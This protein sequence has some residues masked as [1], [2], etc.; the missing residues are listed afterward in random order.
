MRTRDDRFCRGRIADFLSARTWRIA[1]AARWTILSITVWGSASATV[2]PAPGYIDT[3][4]GGGIGDGGAPY[5]AVVD[6][7]GLAFCWGKL[8]IADGQQHR[9]R[10]ADLTAN[11][12]TTLAGTGEAAFGGDGGPAV[13]AKLNT[14]TDV[15]C[16]PDGSLY[17]ADTFNHRVRR[18]APNG[19]I[20]T[21]IGDGRPFSSGDGGPATQ[22]SVNRPQGLALDGNG[23]LYVSE[24]DGYRVRRIAPN[25]IVSTVAGTGQWGSSGDGGP[26]T[27]ARLMNPWGIAVD[28]FGNLFIADYGASRVRRVDTQGIITTVVG[29]G[30]Q[31]FAGDGGPANRARLNRPARL[32]FDLA[33][34][35]YL[36]DILNYRVR[37]VAAVQGLVTGEATIQ[38]IAGT[39]NS[40]DT[41]DFGPATAATFWN[42]WGLAI[43]PAGTIY[44]G[45]FRPS[46]SSTRSVENRVRTIVPSGVVLPLVGGGPGDG[47]IATNAVIEPRGVFAEN[48]G[49]VM[50]VFFAD[51]AHQ[52]VRV[53]DV[54]SGWVTTVAGNGATCSSPTDPCGDGGPAVNAPLGSPMD[55]ARDSSGNL[56]IAEL[57]LHRIRKVDAVTQQISTVAGTGG[58]G[59][60]GDGLPATQSTLAN[61]YAVFVT[62]DASTMYIADFSNL[63]IRRVSS[64]IMTTIAGNGSWGNPPDGAVASQSA[65]GA[66]TDVLLGPD[67]LVYFV[68]NGNHMVRRIARDGTLQRVAGTGWAGFSGDGGPAVSAQLFGP[69][70]ITF[71]ADGNLY[72]ADGNNYRIRRIAAGSGI[73]TTVA[74]T[75]IAGQSGDG[76]LALDASLLRPLGL[77]AIDNFV[78]IGIPEAF[79]IR[80]VALDPSSPPPPTKTFSPTLTMTP[81]AATTSTPTGT[82]TAT[83]V[84]TAT[85][86]LRPT[87]TPT[88]TA[89]PSVTPTVTPTLTR[90][91]TFTPSFTPTST[92]TR[93]P[94]PTPTVTPTPSRTPTTT[95]TPTDTP[96]RTPSF[97]PTFT[98]TPTFTPTPTDTPT[99]TPTLTYTPTRTWTPT[100]TPSLT[101]TVTPTPTDTPTTTPTSTRTPTR[102]WT[103]TRTPTN[104]PTPSR[105]PTDTPTRTWTPTQ[106]ATRT[107]T[108][109]PT[110]TPTRTPTSTGTPTRTPTPSRTPTVSLTSTPTQTSTST[111]THTPT[112]TPAS[113]PTP[114]PTPTGTPTST[115][116]DSQSLTGPQRVAGTIRYHASSAPV[117]EVVLTAQNQIGA[118]QVMTDS[119]GAYEFPSLA[120]T[121]WRISPALAGLPTAV[122][123]SDAVTVLQIM[124]GTKPATPEALLACDVTGNGSLSTGDAVAILRYLVGLAPDLPAVT[125]CGSPWLFVPDVAAPVPGQTLNAPSLTPACSQ[126]SIEFSPLGAPLAGQDFRAVLLGDCNGNWTPPGGFVQRAAH[127]AAVAQAHFG[128]AV[129]RGSR[130]AVPLLRSDNQEVHGLLATVR[131]DRRSWRFVRARPAAGGSDVVVVAHAAADGTV[132]IAAASAASLPLANTPALWLEWRRAA[133]RDHTAPPPRLVELRLE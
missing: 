50:R 57:Y 90:T 115:P 17:V 39:G 84:P 16:A 55:V 1:A 82:P 28:S 130:V 40:G 105:T 132:R 3:V 128:R 69:T 106:T 47:P 85:N 76:Q 104:T 117:P 9:L 24:M 98:S 63:R 95:A 37:R 58:F 108:A 89:T 32:A 25:G 110:E 14:P 122:S 81:T 56:Y 109:T 80:V 97:S 73:I 126:G 22:A 103:A 112:L 5:D 119:S 7:R 21:V 118:L 46:S 77:E 4:V 75:G 131:Y 101:P 62:P 87:A 88:A 100:R 74:G 113:S 92:W 99:V 8:F 30:F 41:G 35:L 79:R 102:T 54:G 12:I 64:G 49:G 78:F 91:P 20:T 34:N 124:V 29:D 13:L 31:G 11:S 86:T 10:Q 66:P 45:Q 36:T 67:G 121:H 133:R 125:A 70:R 94:S 60:N 127:T 96:T 44:L 114:S 48:A 2:L 72:I 51:N 52:R 26:A 93:T 65:I 43:D 116:G 68:D 120:T 111:P 18:I 123:T 61:P 107:P 38:T 129:Y 33:G 53:F 6:P 27:Q 15:L 83:F 23:N 71:D 19:V 42:L 59:F